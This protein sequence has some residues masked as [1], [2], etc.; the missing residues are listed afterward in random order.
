MIGS[1]NLKIRI[2]DD[3]TRNKGKVMVSKV[4]ISQQSNWWHFGAG[5]AECK[6]NIIVVMDRVLWK[7]FSQGLGLKSEP[8]KQQAEIFKFSEQQK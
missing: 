2:Y 6:H 1:G 8:E 5:T 3:K 7:E 4:A